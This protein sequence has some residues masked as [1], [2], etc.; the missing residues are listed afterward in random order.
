MLYNSGYTVLYNLTS[1]IVRLAFCESKANIKQIPT[2]EVVE[3]WTIFHEHYSLLT[4][5]SNMGC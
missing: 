5:P 3:L 1:A 4:H 2:V